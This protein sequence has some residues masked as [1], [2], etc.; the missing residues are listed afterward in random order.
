MMKP[1]RLTL[2]AQEQAK[3]RGALFD[4]IE[5]AIQRGQ[6][7]I[8]KKGR[9]MAKANFEF[10]DQWGER[11][12]AIKQVAPVFVEEEAEIVVITVYT[13]YF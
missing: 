12:H 10:N 4:E 6:W 11:H 13:Y 5:T 7:E 2:H 3:L 1:I 9:Q 8:V